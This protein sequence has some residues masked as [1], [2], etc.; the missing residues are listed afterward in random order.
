MFLLIVARCHVILSG[1]TIQNRWSGLDG[2]LRQATI[3]PAVLAIVLAFVGGL[4]LSRLLYEGLFPHAELLS[5][6]LPVFLLGALTAVLGGSLFRWLERR[7]SSSWAALLPF[8][9]RGLS[10][11]RYLP[12]FK[13]A[14]GAYQQTK[15]NAN[16]PHP[17]GDLSTEE[18]CQI[19]GL[20]TH[21]T[22]DEVIA[23]HRS[24][25]QKLHPDRG[26]STYLA[27]QLNAAKRVLLKN[28]G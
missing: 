4:A 10:L 1:M 12:W 24:L 7:Q 2:W 13:S 25:M 28:I 9:K 21:P 6:P 14:Y 16:T 3:A 26:G 8:L 19:L 15:G 17:S 22:R 11:I 27:Q 18:A 20:G 23:A 5:R